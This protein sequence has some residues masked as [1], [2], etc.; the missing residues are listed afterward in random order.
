MMRAKQNSRKEAMEKY[1]EKWEQAG[2]GPVPV[3]YDVNP[4]MRSAN[5][6]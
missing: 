1:R 4:L 6:M 3:T 5:G 2:K